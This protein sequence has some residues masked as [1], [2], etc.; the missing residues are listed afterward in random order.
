VR[1]KLEPGSVV[2]ADNT[3]QATPVIDADD[4]L[5]SVRGEE[6]PADATAASIGIAEYLAHIH[7]LD[8]F[9]TA[10]LPLGDGVAVTVRR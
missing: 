2:L 10:L 4:V 6:V 3:I 9:T 8:S 7:S 5:S 1:E